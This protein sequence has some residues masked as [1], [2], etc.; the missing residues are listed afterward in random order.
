[1][2]RSR[3]RFTRVYTEVGKETTK[4]PI[5]KGTGTELIL[6]YEDF[7]FKVDDKD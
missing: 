2:D 5:L 6:Y 1:M 4:R 3:G 7:H